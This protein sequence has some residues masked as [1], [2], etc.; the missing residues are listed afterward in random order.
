MG[1]TVVIMGGGVIG[2][3]CAFELQR[4]GHQ[5]ILLEINRCG[6]QASGAAAGMLAPFSENVEGP[7]AFFHLGKESLRL[8][9]GWRDAIRSISGRY[10]EYSDSGSLYIAYHEADRLALEGRL[11]WQR[12]HGSSGVLLEGDELFRKEPLLSRQVKAALYTPAESHLYAPDYV[13]ALEH[14]CRLTG[15]HFHEQLGGL[16]VAEWRDA[17]VVQAK[18]G[19][20][21]GGDRLL[22]CTGAWAQELEETLGIRIPVYPIR[23][24]ICAYE[25][26]INPVHHMV[27]SNQGYLVSKENG[28]LVCGASEDVAGFDTTVTERGIERLRNWNKQ[29]FP[30]LAEQTPFHRWAGLRPSTQDGYP[31][32]GP[33]EESGR[34]IMAAGHYRNGILLSPVT[35]KAVAD[36]IDG[37][38][39]PEMMEAFAPGRFTY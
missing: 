16:E 18:D 36:Y 12:E 11:L 20:R 7:D 13:E 32:L 38:K 2:L 17:V 31:L 22:V 1:E 39:L 21:F 35:A 8:Y 6:G 34:V 37:I 23:G 28:T 9:P 30:F 10:F 4:R 24:Q 26:E 33:L 15:V 5:A 27:F 14:A 3:S 25:A 19:R 29:A